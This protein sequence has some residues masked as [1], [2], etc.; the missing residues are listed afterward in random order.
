MSYKTGSVF[1]VTHMWYAVVDNTSNL[2]TQ[3][4]SYKTY[5]VWSEEWEANIPVVGDTDFPTVDF[6]ATAAIALDGPVMLVRFVAPVKC[7]LV[8]L[9]YTIAFT[10]HTAGDSGQLRIAAVKH[11][12]TQGTAYGDDATMKVLGWLDT[13]ADIDALEVGYGF[14]TFTGTSTDADVDSGNIPALSTRVLEPGEGMGF[15]MEG[16]DDS[17]PRTTFGTISA[18]LMVI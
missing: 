13:H 10:H 12:C 9:G 6:T 8:S 18:T 5:P 1:T 4:L 17:N 11:E 15:T 16:K 7:R 3:Y 2:H 14:G